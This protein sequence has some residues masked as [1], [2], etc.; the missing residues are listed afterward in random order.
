MQLAKTNRGSAFDYINLGLASF[1][2]KDFVKADSAFSQ[3]IRV[4]E[5]TVNTYWKA[6]NASAIDDKV[7]EE[8]RK[9]EEDK[10]TP[11]NTKEEKLKSYAKPFWE[12]YI[13]LAEKDMEKDK[14][15]K[16]RVSEGYYRFANIAANFDGDLQKAED[17]LKKAI[18][19]K[20]DYENAKNML[21]QVEEFKKASNAPKTNQPKPEE[22][23]R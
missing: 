5:N 7:L 4:Q 19:I 8:K 21:K 16:D 15:V 6:K 17:F 14:K 22:K 1:Y 2:M 3:S 12:R 9:A 18:E 20:P 10:R 11:K 13:A 23:K